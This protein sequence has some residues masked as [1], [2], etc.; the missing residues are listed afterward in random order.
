MEV[1]GIVKDLEGI[2]IPGA[3]ITDNAGNGA[4]TDA[5]G[6]YS[7]TTTSGAPLKL[8]YFGKVYEKTANASNINWKID[9]N[10]EINEVTI[11]G[12]RVK[13]STVTAVGVLLLLAALWYGWKKG[14]LKALFA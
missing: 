9:A 14:Y 10:V 1:S 3:I 8:E 6:E 7:F 2:T 12:Y 11:I 5:D 4:A 13:K